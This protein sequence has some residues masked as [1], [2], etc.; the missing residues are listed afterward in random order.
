MDNKKNF[1]SLLRAVQVPIIP[2]KVCFNLFENWKRQNYKG[3]VYPGN[4]CAGAPLKDSCTVIIV[5]LH[6]GNSRGFLGLPGN[7]ADFRKFLRIIQYVRAFQ[8]IS[9]RFQSI[10]KD[11]EVF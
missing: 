4:I 10:P 1:P 8:R 9:K 6:P 11:S 3:R 5:I 2:Y 7:S